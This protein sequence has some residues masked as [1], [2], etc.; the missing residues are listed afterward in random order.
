[1]KVFWVLAWSKYYPAGALHNVRSMWATREEAEAAAA[2][3]NPDDY[4]YIRVQDVSGMLGIGDTNE[5]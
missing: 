2:E 3:I 5:L 1:M 4:D